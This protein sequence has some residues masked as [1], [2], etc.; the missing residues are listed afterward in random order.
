MLKKS[1]FLK[2]LSGD[3]ATSYDV[4][5]GKFGVDIFKVEDLV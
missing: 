2:A 1:Q 4:C 3:L 5:Y